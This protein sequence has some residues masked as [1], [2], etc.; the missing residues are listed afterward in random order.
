MSEMDDLAAFAVLIEAG[1]FTLAAQ[2]LGCSKGQL[3]KRI[4]QLEAQ[5]SV[6]LLQ[7]TTRRLSLTA[8]G[9]ALLPQAQALVVQ[10]ERARQ[11]LAR[12]KDDMA[13]PVRMTV[14][15]SLGETFFD[16]LLLEFSGQYPEVQIELELDNS[17]RDLAR[18]GFDLA[19]RAEV[20]ND[21]R[22]VAKPLLAWHEMTCAS[23]AYLERF[24]EPATPHALAEHR[25]LLNSH[26]SGREE[27]LYHQQHELLRVRV[28]GPFASNHY[29]LLKKAALSGAG[30]ARL[31]SYLLQAELADG[32]L[33]WLLRD[34]QTRR[35]PMYLV[36][37][38]QGGL[39][40][41]TQVLADYL[42]GW[43][44]R[45]GEALDRLQR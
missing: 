22:L 24:G 45:S 1:S 10:V 38:Y 8:A 27:W 9:A 12:L 3:S 41:R 2:Q 18:D 17:Y 31:P 13:G 14:P 37:P 4:S 42:M 21:D 29:S 26:Y 20:A 33:R 15:V 40:K 16:G 5:F 30:I 35:M 7:R 34:Y 39:P 32:R 44:K 43:F 23:P 36:H 11:A 25:C 19:I 28:S 6:V